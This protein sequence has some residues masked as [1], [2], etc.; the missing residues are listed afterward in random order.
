MIPATVG[1]ASFGNHNVV[2]HTMTPPLPLIA[3]TGD[4]IELVDKDYPFNQATA[5][6]LIKGVN[7]VTKYFDNGGNVWSSKIIPQNFKFTLLT[8]LLAKTFY[9]PK[10]KV[11]RIWTRTQDY[12]I[13]ELK[14]SIRF[15][16]GK[17]NDILTQF[18]EAEN[19]KSKLQEC[20]NF[21]DIVDMLFN[22]IYN[23]DEE[24][25]YEEFP[26]GD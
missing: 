18:V 15:C 8:R 1:V 23:P 26:S 7:D 13:E 16:I 4:F 20:C 2:C 9:N 11:D 22:Y 14:E 12:N 5:Y 10:I 19:L 21:Q 3:I 6:G 17:D 24:K 25:I